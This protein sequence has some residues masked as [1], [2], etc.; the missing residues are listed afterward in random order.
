MITAIDTNILIDIFGADPKHGIRSK[1]A[2]QSCIQLGSIIACDVV[3]AEVTALFPRT[4]M[5]QEALKA[6]GVGYSPLDVEA[7]LKAGQLWKVYR[8]KGGTRTRMVADFLIGAHAF[9]QADALLTRDRGFYRSGIPSLN[10]IDPS[11]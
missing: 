9:H 2:L 1:D 4:T 8:N 6:L 10:I 5:A 7:S 3:W 11:R